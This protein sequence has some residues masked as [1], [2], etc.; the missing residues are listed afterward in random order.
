MSLCGS[1]YWPGQRLSGA[2]HAPAPPQERARGAAR[3][4]VIRDAV[5][6]AGLGSSWGAWWRG[7]SSQEGSSPAANARQGPSCPLIVR[8]P[9]AVLA[10]PAP[11]EYAAQR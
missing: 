11:S 6:S 8:D 4:S 5:E 2:M 1:V 9:R 10:L 7:E 3:V